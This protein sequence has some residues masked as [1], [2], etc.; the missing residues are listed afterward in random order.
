MQYNYI[1]D[2]YGFQ[3]ADVTVMVDD[4]DHVQP[5]K[6]NILAAYHNVVRQSR[7]G[8]AIF[9]HFSGHGTKVRDL[10]GDEDDGYDEALVP[11]DFK[12]SGVIIDDDLYDIF[13]K[14]LPTGVHVVAVVRL[15]CVCIHVAFH[16]ASSKYSVIPPSF[17]IFSATVAILEQLWIYRTFSRPTASIAA[18]RLKIN[19]TLTSFSRCWVAME[20]IWS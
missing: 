5:T 9:L 6:A 11:L 2:F 20:T 10:N 19:L 14:G 8:D 16:T 18:W 3:D 12:Q 17:H 1:Q 7:E 15:Q 4:G 13:V